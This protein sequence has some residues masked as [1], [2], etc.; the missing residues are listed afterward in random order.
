M[1]GHSRGETNSTWFIGETEIQIE[2][3]NRN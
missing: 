1:I 3:A 2:G